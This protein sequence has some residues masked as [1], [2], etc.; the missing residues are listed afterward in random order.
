MDW[1]DSPYCGGGSRINRF[2]SVIKG[3]PG[4]GE[5]E[6]SV[7]LANEEASFSAIS[8]GAKPL[9]TMVS[10]EYMRSRTKQ[11]FSN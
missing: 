6:K 4:V 10:L 2:R 5:P 8:K 3:E 7:G 11:A 9:M 1:A